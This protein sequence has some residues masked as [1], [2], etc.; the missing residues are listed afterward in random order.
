MSLAPLPHNP[1][2]FRPETACLQGPSVLWDEDHRGLDTWMCDRISCG[3][4][5]KMSHVL[6]KWFV[7]AALVTAFVRAVAGANLRR[8]TATPRRRFLKYRERMKSFPPRNHE[9]GE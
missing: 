6:S 1:R 3:L 9:R 5:S 4:V 2:S 8:L 7:L